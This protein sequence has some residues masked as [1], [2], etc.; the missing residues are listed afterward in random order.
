MKKTNRLIPLLLACLLLVTLFYNV[1]IASACEGCTMYDDPDWDPTYD[2]HPEFDTDHTDSG[3]FGYLNRNVQV[4]DTIT[5]EWVQLNKGCKVKILV[6][7]FMDGK[8]TYSVDFGRIYTDVPVNA[9]DWTKPVDSEKDGEHAMAPGYAPHPEFRTDDTDN[10]KF[11]YLNRNVQVYDTIT[12]EWVQ[13]NKGCKVKILVKVFT[14]DKWTYSVDFGR[15][16]TDVPVNAIDWTNS[17]DSEKVE[18]HGYMKHDVQV[19]NSAGQ[20]VQL[21][22]GCWV[23]FA[24]LDKS[25]NGVYTYTITFGSYGTYTGVPIDSIDWDDGYTPFGTSTKKEE[26]VKK[27]NSKAAQTTKKETSQTTQP[28]NTEKSTAEK[29][30]PSAKQEVTVCTADRYRFFADTSGLARKQFPRNMILPVAFGELQMY[31]R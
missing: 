12:N 20:K 15:I 24:A 18:R 8:W 9:I 23:A 14:A 30:K 31:L 21:N 7:V 11:G 22:Q 2:P 29:N 3:K 4:Y 16:Y 27:D 25:T 13:L 19:Y 10:G 17:A 26:T 28:A 5:N 6:K 1:P